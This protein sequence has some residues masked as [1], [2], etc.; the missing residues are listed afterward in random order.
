MESFKSTFVD[1][2]DSMA[3]LP[4]QKMS[5]EQSREFLIKAAR[6][7]DVNT[8]KKFVAIKPINIDLVNELSNDEIGWAPLHF[9]SD[10]GHVEIVELLIR[11]FSAKVD[12]QTKMG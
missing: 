5:I 1:Y 10:G 2:S 12:L 8:V 3:E 6:D 4:K 11:K 7:G 9:A